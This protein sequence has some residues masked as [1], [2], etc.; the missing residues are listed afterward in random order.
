MNRASHKNSLRKKKKLSNCGQQKWKQ[1]KTR[2]SPYGTK[3]KYDEREKKEG[4][5]CKSEK[6]RK[7]KFIKANKKTDNQRELKT[8]RNNES[9]RH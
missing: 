7:N 5:E 8:A 9:Q 2:Q 3:K 6:Q 1:I 4:E